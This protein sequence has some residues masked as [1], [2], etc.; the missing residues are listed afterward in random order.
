MPTAA[1]QRCWMDGYSSVQSSSWSEHVA[2]IE[3]THRIMDKLQ[4]TDKHITLRSEKAH[5][6]SEY[7]LA[8]DFMIMVRCECLRACLNV[9]I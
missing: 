5:V 3:D 7:I 2:H 1:L 6:S 8:M 4:D 9:L